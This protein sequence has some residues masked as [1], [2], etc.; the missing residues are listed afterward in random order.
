VKAAEDLVDYAPLRVLQPP[1]RQLL[2]DRIEIFDA[3]LRIGS[4]DAV[5]DRLQRDL[6]A[7]LLLEQRV[8]EQLALGYVQIDADDAMSTALLVDPGL[9]ATHH[10][11]VHAIAVTQPVHA[12]EQ[13]LDAG[14]VIAQRCTHALEVVRMHQLLPIGQR[15]D[16][17][18][19]VAEH[20]LPAR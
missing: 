9:R 12:L 4:D 8:L 14:E 17:I 6:R 13:R 5:A 10:P 15:L 16:L 2:G 20:R 1:T 11:Q 3:A 7:L 19:A 18:V